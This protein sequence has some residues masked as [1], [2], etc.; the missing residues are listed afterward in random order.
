VMR[1]KRHRFINSSHNFWLP[2]SH[3]CAL[4]FINALICIASPFFRNRMGIKKGSPPNIKCRFTISAAKF[5]IMSI[6]PEKETCFRFRLFP[7]RA[8]KM[9]PN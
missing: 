8:P 6:S 1:G 9:H 7:T 2:K 4:I 5:D 3:A